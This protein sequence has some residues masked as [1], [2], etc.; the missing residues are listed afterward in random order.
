MP[1]YIV[2]DESVSGHCCFK[3]SVVDDTQKEWNEDFK[4]Y[5]YGDPICETY[6]Q[7]DAQLIC[8]LLN[9]ADNETSN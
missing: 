6:E 4:R 8:K 2:V 9:E 7:A 3:Y 1:K 5:F